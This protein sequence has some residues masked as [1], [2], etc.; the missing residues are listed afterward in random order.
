M[1]DD[2]AVTYTGEQA[3]ELAVR[4]GERNSVH[5]RSDRFYQIDKEFYFSTREGIE[6]GPFGSKGEAASG[7]ERFIQSIRVGDNHKKAT[8]VALSGSWAITNFQ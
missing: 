4:A 5:F 6:I 2:P 7:L 1:M 8:Q 3:P